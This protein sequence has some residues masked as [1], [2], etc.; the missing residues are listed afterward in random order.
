MINRQLYT[1]KFNSSRLKRYKYNI[2]I[3]YDE[4][5]R[6][7]EIAPL[8][9]SQMLRSIRKVLV[10]RGENHRILDRERLEDLYLLKKKNKLTS[11]QKQEILN[12]TYVPEYITIVM[13]HET[14]YDY[15]FNNGV[16]INGMLYKR[17][18]CSAGQARVSTV[19]FCS[20]NILDK[21]K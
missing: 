19:V 3:T 1:L 13:E 7:D 15:L 6:N 20:V 4:A 9:E 5:K 2:N 8:A 11:E 21:V 18:S 10:E 16:T 17:L 14:H 12:M